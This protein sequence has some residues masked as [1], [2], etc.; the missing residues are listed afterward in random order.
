MG[1]RVRHIEGTKH[2]SRDLAVRHTD[3]SLIQEPWTYKGQVLGIELKGGSLVY[4]ESEQGPRACIFI[5]RKHTALKLHQFCT[6]DLAVASIKIPIGETKADIIIGSAYLPY[7]DTT[8]PT[9]EVIR[10]V[11]HCKVNDLP[12]IVG[13]DANA[14]HIVWG[15]SDINRRGSAL[16]EY[17]STTGLEIL[18]EGSKPTFV[19]SRRQE[20]I[21]ITLGSRRIAQEIRRLGSQQR[22]F[23][24]RP[25]TDKLLV[26]GNNSNGTQDTYRNPKSADWLKYKKS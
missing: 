21:D 12:L 16:L 11:E 7:E 1:E 25:Q 19:T 5:N 14:H 24:F 13:C 8:V 6:R 23:S 17:L 15:S 4:G 20:V 26:R 2:P 22:G 9:E 3:V 18:N 10:L